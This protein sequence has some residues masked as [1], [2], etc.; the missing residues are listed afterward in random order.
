MSNKSVA[1][2]ASAVLAFMLTGC[3]G[4][5]P[6]PKIQNESNATE[7]KSVAVGEHAATVKKQCQDYNEL[8]KAVSILIEQVEELGAKDRNSLAVVVDAGNNGKNGLNGKD[9]ASPLSDE[10]RAEL[11]SLRAEL[12]ALKSQF[13]TLPKMRKDTPSNILVDQQTV[14]NLCRDITLVV[15][16]PKAL[17][18]A[19]YN[20]SV[21]P[22]PSD[23]SKPMRVIKR[24]TK[25]RYLGCDDYGWC[26][27]KDGS[28]FVK[29]FQLTKIK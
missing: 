29:G 6:T 12:D 26:E 9:G 13:D 19:K 28:G 17:Y 24:N 27:L 16:D 10:E 14:K 1:F 21:Y 20:L 3:G 23:K 2:M 4:A 5:E 11:K 15:I 7:I 22:C 8:K 18:K 25:V